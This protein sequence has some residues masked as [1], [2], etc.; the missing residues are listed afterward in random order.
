[1]VKQL[2][3]MKDSVILGNLVPFD[4]DYPW[5]YCHFTPT[6]EFLQYKD[7]FDREWEILDQEKSS[8]DNE[9]IQA[10]DQVS[11]LSLKLIDDDG[12]ELG[13]FL[14]HIYNDEAWYRE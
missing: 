11:H 9:W 4:T 6:P 8:D 10:Y 3:L 14:I 2:T 13:A 1:V 7:L 12:K 5:V